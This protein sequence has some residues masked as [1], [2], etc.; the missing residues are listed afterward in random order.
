MTTVGYIFV[1][2]FW[3]WCILAIHFIGLLGETLPIVAAGIFAAGVALALFFLPNRKRTA[4]CVLALCAGII[5]GWMQ[6]GPY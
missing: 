2:G 5:I 1:F 3:L 4:Y 6:K